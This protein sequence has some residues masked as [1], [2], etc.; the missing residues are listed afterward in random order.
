MFSGFRS[1]GFNEHSVKKRETVCLPVD[2]IE[3]MQMF[4]C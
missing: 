4:Q 2:D 3:F 1:L